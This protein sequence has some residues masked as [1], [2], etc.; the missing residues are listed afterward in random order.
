ML[1]RHQSVPQIS[2]M[3]RNWSGRFCNS[4]GWSTQNRCWGPEPRMETF[5]LTVAE[6][7]RK[8][9]RT[10]SREKITLS[11]VRLNIPLCPAVYDAQ[12]TGFF[13]WCL[14]SLRSI[15][16]NYTSHQTAIY[17][18]KKKNNTGPHQKRECPAG[19]NLQC[20]VKDFCYSWNVCYTNESEKGP[21]IQTPEVIKQPQLE[22]KIWK[23][24][25][26][27]ETQP[28]YDAS[29]KFPALTCPTGNKRQWQWQSAWHCCFSFG[30]SGQKVLSHNNLLEQTSHL[31]L[32]PFSYKA[33]KSFTPK[34]TDFVVFWLRSELWI[35]IC[36][37]LSVV[38]SIGKPGPGML[39]GNFQWYGSYEQ[40]KSVSVWNGTT[41]LSGKYCLPQVQ[42]KF[43]SET[44]VSDLRL[45]SFQ[46][47]CNF[48]KLQ[49]W[50]GWAP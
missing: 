5:Q 14:C 16:S 48:W 20:N 45:S 37:F 36:Q 47:N 31:E 7:W 4:P 15:E 41:A 42:V 18:Q 35:F 46:R 24:P 40:C 13:L 29:H 8:S 17:C 10:W 38:D 33:E 44:V 6:M 28:K 25:N 12:R 39:D 2:R 1:R 34:K 49:S 32:K 21:T 50:S 11:E 3:T 27:T 9:W 22:E 23:I 43:C 19:S 30:K 26:H